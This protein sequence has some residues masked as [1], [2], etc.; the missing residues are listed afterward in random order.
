M[1]TEEFA[2][3]DQRYTPA[4]ESTITTIRDLNRRK[5]PNILFAGL[6]ITIECAQVGYLLDSMHSPGADRVTYFGN[7]LEEAISG[8]IRL[9]RQTS[10]VD[11]FRASDSWI[12]VVNN[13]DRLRHYFDP[14]GEGG[15]HALAR[16]L[17]FVP[18]AAAAHAALADRPWSAV[19]VLN[20]SDPDVDNLLTAAA[21]RRIIRILC[22]AQPLPPVGERPKTLDADV[23]V[24]GENLTDNQIPFGCYVMTP[25]AYRVW[26]N[27]VDAM[28]QTSTFAASATALT[29]VVN[30]L[31][32]KGYVAAHQER[33]LAAIEAD[34]KVRNEYFRRYVNPSAGDM[35]EAF[36]LDFDFDRADGMEISLRDGRSLLDCACGTGA[37]LRGHN[38]PDLEKA[39]AAHDQS[40][41]YVGQLADYLCDR[42]GFDDMFPA[43][44]GATSVENA[45][46]LARL[47]R[48]G[49]PRI[50]TFSG[51]FSGKTI[52]TLNVSRYGPQRS[53]S[54]PG[55][56]EPYYSDVIFIDPFAATAA[57]DLRAAL[58]DPQVGLFWCELI[59]GTT[60]EIIPA[61]LLEVVAAA[62][63][64][65]GFVVGVD[66]VLTGV[67]RSADTFLYHETVLDGLVDIVTLAKPLSDM[68]VPVAA[69]LARAEVVAAAEATDV[70]AVQ[71][72]RTRYRNNLGAHIAVNAL[73]AVDNPAAHEQRRTEREAL[74]RGL[75]ALAATS[76]L[77]RSVEGAGIHVR[78]DID[79]RYFPFRENT[80]LSEMIDQSIEDLILRRCG[81]I[82]GRGRFFPP[83]Y[84]PAGAMAQVV[85]RLHRGFDGFTVVT[86][87]ANL[88]RNIA[89]FASFG[90]RRQLGALVKRVT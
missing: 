2:L 89:A 23:Y 61:E 7:S 80:V 79:R 90:I 33:V 38:L 83:I 77:V 54:I 86:V 51:N 35:M 37:N 32:S 82:L 44:S 63:A 20:D 56:F 17:C 66:E 40:T 52:T 69:T 15:E 12:L 26:N 13:D 43:V 85:D 11:D 64:E 65:Q 62:K 5:R 57:H 18:T 49:R 48:P 84:P 10:K 24:Y 14:L 39:L 21:E 3:T 78:I 4:T 27:P 19:L 60:C 75:E 25:D 53:A 34:R 28:A 8:A 9:V 47:A 68:T 16:H 6:A 30:T 22:D 1:T 31:R 67:W 55:A 74:L 45:L 59:Q 87:Y 88:V 81:V 71:R 41:D 58:D 29:L 42:S 76:P 72:L 36:G 70:E 73:R 46:V 50:V